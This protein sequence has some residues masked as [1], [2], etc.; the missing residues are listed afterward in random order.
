MTAIERLWA[1]DYR[2]PAEDA[3]HFADGRSYEVALTP[4]SPT[5]V[6]VLAPF[7]LDARLAEDPSWVSSVDG[8]ASLYLG[9]G[10][11]LW[12]GEGSHGSE[13]F[14]ARLTAD[15][16]L[17]WALFFADSNPFT[18]IRL[19]GNVA[20]FRSTSEFDIAVDIDDPRVPVSQGRR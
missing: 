19:S 7:D 6:T 3:L 16:R 12:G 5:G 1:D 17:V 10:G 20:V 15:R 14:I 9:S 2:L 4:E 18:R 13:G 8:L 11:M